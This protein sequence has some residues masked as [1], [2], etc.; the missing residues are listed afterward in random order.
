MK[1]LSNSDIAE[2]VYESDEPAD[3]ASEIMSD[4]VQLAQAARDYELFE[5]I[6]ALILF[7]DQAGRPHLTGHDE[8]TPELAESAIS[9]MDPDESSAEIPGYYVL[10]AAIGEFYGSRY[11]LLTTPKEHTDLF[12]VLY[13]IAADRAIESA[14]ANRE[15]AAADAAE[16]RRE[17]CAWHEYLP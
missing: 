7:W 4:P 5:Q 9:A 16:A 12:N 3:T 6:D 1:Y 17:W 10:A 14:I 8:I 15:S 13:G 11:S 2:R